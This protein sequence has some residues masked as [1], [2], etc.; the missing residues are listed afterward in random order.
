MAT[1]SHQSPNIPEAAKKALGGKGKKL[2]SHGINLR[3]TANK[4]WIAN[5]E[6]R[7]ANGNPPMDGQRGAMEYA[8]PDQAAMLKHLQ[9]HSGEIAEEEE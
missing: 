3:R 5:H 9:E 8:L 2:H 6:L 4:G 1:P 7:D